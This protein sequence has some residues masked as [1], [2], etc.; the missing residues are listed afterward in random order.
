MD[1]VVVLMYI[2]Q[3]TVRYGVVFLFLREMPSI[4]QD[5]ILIKNISTSL[6]R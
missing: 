4:C 3:D 1:K 2:T 5:I 6:I